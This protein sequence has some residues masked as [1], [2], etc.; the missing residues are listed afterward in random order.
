[1]GDV[2]QGVSQVAGGI[3]EGVGRAQFLREQQTARQQE[4]DARQQL[5]EQRITADRE[6]LL[7]QLQNRLT[8][9]EENIQAQADLVGVQRD[10]DIQKILKRGEVQDRIQDSEHFNLLKRIEAQTGAT[11][12]IKKFVSELSLEELGAKTEAEKELITERFLV[13]SQAEVLRDARKLG[14][15]RALQGIG[16]EFQEKVENLRADIADRQFNA[17]S[18]KELAMKRQLAELDAAL[19]FRASPF[20]LAMYMQKEGATIDP[21]TKLPTDPDFFNQPSVA[22][23]SI[24]KL[25]A[26]ENFITNGSADVAAKGIRMQVGALPRNPDGSLTEEGN[27]RLAAIMKSVADAPLNQQMVGK[28]PVLRPRK[29]PTV[30]QSQ[31]SLTQPI[32]STPVTRVRSLTGQGVETSQDRWAVG[33]AAGEILRTGNTLAAMGGLNL[34]KNAATRFKLSDTARAAYNRANKDAPN[35]I[36]DTSAEGQMQPV[37]RL[38]QR[39]LIPEGV[40]D[41]YSFLTENMLGS[42]RAWAGEHDRYVDEVFR[43]LDLM[44]GR[45]FRSKGK[46]PI[47]QRKLVLD[48]LKASGVTLDRKDYTQRALNEKSMR[49]MAFV[50]GLYHFWK[51]PGRNRTQPLQE[52]LASR[53]WDTVDVGAN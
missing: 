3:A 14:M 24:T 20:V 22:D 19:S 48:I 8:I 34:D 53:Y 6:N 39:D 25:D 2:G 26:I 52:M 18:A 15:E 28:K 42:Q 7:S 49:R 17:R 11:K 45:N 50:G 21:N 41:P 27:R 12:D 47:G 5:Q 51:N 1:M 29:T 16:F 32:T 33:M 46:K 23:P 40:Q 4:F 30:T 9:A 37:Q 10:A 38:F 13:Q 31:T 35:L 44:E 43:W 36:A